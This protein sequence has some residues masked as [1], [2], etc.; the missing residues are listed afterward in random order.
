MTLSQFSSFDIDFKRWKG[1]EWRW[2]EY[3]DDDRRNGNEC[4]CLKIID[5]KM[6]DNDDMIN[7]NRWYEGM[8]LTEEN[9]RIE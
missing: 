5:W 3:C 8:R 1:I 6:D 2:S 4:I 9:K 7:F